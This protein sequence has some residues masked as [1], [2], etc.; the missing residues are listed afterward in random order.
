VAV[1][2]FIYVA[3]CARRYLQVRPLNFRDAQKSVGVL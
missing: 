1:M 2:I 3:S